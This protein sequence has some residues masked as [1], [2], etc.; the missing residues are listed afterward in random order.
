MIRELLIDADG[1]Y[2]F[3][4]GVLAILVARRNG[5]LFRRV[6]LFLIIKMI[7][8]AQEGNSSGAACG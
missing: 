8:P 4:W 6:I 7:F 2:L 3:S 5:H 1:A